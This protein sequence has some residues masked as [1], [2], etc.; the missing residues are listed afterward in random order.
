MKLKSW[1]G[2]L[3]KRNELVHKSKSNVG[4]YVGI[5]RTRVGMQFAYQGMSRIQDSKKIRSKEFSMRDLFSTQEND[6]QK[7]EDVLGANNCSY[8]INGSPRRRLL[9]LAHHR[10]ERRKKKR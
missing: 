10:C 9:K 5:Y 3:M 7:V 4:G 8:V 2:A 6:F 1:I